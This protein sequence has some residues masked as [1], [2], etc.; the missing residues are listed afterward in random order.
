ME[1]GN[2]QKIEIRKKNIVTGF[3]SSSSDNTETQGTYKTYFQKLIDELRE[4]YKFTNA[5]VGQPQN[6]YSFASENSKVFKY[7]TSFAQNDRVRTEIYIDIGEQNKNK[8]IFD[9]LYKEKEIIEK[10]FGSAL[11][12]ERLDEKRACRVAAY[13]DGT[14]SDDTQTLENTKKWAIENLLKFK[15]VFPK[16][17]EKAN[18][19]AA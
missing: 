9:N 15:K 10:E 6:W 18:T 11:V 17:I 12:W 8:N 5:K 1:F 3:N 13:I 19:P 14:I 2:L 7:G 4:K 16:H